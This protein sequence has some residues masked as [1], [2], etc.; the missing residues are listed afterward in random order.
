M[1]ASLTALTWTLRRFKWSLEAEAAEKNYDIGNRELLAVTMALE[2]WCHW[3]EGAE[4]PF[5]VWT[6]HKNL[7]YIKAAK[8]LNCRRP[9]GLCSLEGLP[10]CLPIAPARRMASQTHSPGNMLKMGEMLHLSL[11]LNLVSLAW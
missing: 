10:L 9:S 4:H 8:R 6:N 1:A 5:T 11:S 7:E 2:E 3:L